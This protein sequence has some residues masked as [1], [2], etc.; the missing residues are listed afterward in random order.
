MGRVATEGKARVALGHDGDGKL[1]AVALAE[2]MLA[3]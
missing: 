1:L 3:R 2:E